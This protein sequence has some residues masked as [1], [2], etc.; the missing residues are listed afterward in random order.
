M[1]TKEKITNISLSI[2]GIILIT[3]GMMTPGLF[4]FQL[5]AC[6]IGGFMVGRY[7]PLSIISFK[8]E[9]KNDEPDPYDWMK[10]NK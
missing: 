5:P 4:P 8:K 6:F 1:K 10:N 9:K 3:I 7:I 2:L